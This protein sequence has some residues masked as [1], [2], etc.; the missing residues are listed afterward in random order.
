MKRKVGIT[1]TDETYKNLELLCKRYGL[2][3]SQLIALLINRG[4]LVKSN[5]KGET[6]V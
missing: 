6:L 3:K 4:V 2:T 5:E 1:L